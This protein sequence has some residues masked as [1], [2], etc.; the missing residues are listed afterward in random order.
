[1]LKRTKKKS[2]TELDFVVSTN[3]AAKAAN[4]AIALIEAAYAHDP[5]W[6]VYLLQH[7]QILLLAG[8]RAESPYISFSPLITPL[9]L[10]R[11]RYFL[12]ENGFELMHER[13]SF[14]K[15]SHVYSMQNPRLFARLPEMYEFLQ[16]S[17]YQWHAPTN[18]DAQAVIEWCFIVERRLA[19]MMED[20]Q[21]PRTWLFDWWAPH[22]L[23][24]GMLLG[25]PGAAISSYL[26]A[27][28]KEKHSGKTSDLITIGYQEPD[29]LL[30]AE[31]SFSTGK[32]TIQQSEIVYTHELWTTVISTVLRHFESAGLGKNSVFEKEFKAYKKSEK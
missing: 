11:L 6:L 21:L 28:A 19:Q 15:P 14:E 25:Y 1:M 17:T 2:F 30:G 20:G 24:F 5:G 23:R 3:D 26:W 27:G 31:V 18:Y 13:A 4:K 32:K 12:V 10:K 29:E 16:S 22:N 8:L 9:R 7:S